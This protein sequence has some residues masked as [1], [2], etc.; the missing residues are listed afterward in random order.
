MFKII[1]TKNKVDIADKTNKNNNQVFWD[2]GN[3][4]EWRN[5]A[6]ALQ[7]FTIM[8]AQHLS[9]CKAVLVSRSSRERHI[10]CTAKALQ[11]FATVKQRCRPLLKSCN[12]WHWKHSIRQPEYKRCLTLHYRCTTLQISNKDFQICKIKTLKRK[13]ITG[14]SF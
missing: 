8:V 10:S 9:V 11:N 4:Y 3:P 6:A 2:D 1:S 12:E 14:G 5:A 7:Q 13:Y